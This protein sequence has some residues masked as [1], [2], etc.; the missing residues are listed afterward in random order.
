MSEQAR[1]ILLVEDHADTRIV[2]ASLLQQQGYNVL[3]ADSVATALD[4]IDNQTID[5]LISDIGLPDG[6]G[7]DI[8]RAHRRIPA[9]AISGYSTE[10]VIAESHRAGFATHLVK[11]VAIR[12]LVETI[13]EMLDGGSLP[14]SR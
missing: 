5:L 10:D 3:V 9:I 8:A 13:N 14:H 4:V 2:L 12:T 11:P 7:W 1:R 6:S